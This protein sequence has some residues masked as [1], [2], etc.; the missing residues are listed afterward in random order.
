LTL[1]RAKVPHFRIYDLRS[2]YAT[3]L[4]AGGAADEWVTQRLRQGDT[5]V[6]KKAGQDETSLPARY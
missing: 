2:T 6:F 3:R 5:N 1:G 4:S